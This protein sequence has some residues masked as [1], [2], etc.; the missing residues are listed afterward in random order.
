MIA[1]AEVGQKWPREE[2]AVVADV[3]IESRE[4]NRLLRLIAWLLGLNF[5]TLVAILIVE[6]FKAPNV[7][8]R[9]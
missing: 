7:T 1:K 4:R 2:T 3:S 8:F 5:V 6:W 9:F